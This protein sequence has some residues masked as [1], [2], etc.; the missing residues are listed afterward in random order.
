MKKLEEGTELYSVATGRIVVW[1]RKSRQA[2]RYI[3]RLEGFV[4]MTP[5]DYGGTLWLFDSLNHAKSA[6]NM[7]NL[8]GIGTGNNI[9]RFTYENKQLVF[10]EEYAKREGLNG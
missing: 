4:A 5:V 10:D 1:K 6:R 2:V 7:M 8:K 9:C 3:S